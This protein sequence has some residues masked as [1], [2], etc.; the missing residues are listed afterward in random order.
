MYGKFM[1]MIVKI[2]NIMIKCIYYDID[3]YIYLYVFLF[4]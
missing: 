2:L 1:I 4:F 3:M